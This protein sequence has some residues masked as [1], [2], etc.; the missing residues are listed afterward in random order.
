MAVYELK[1]NSIK[2]SAC[3]AVISK[4]AQKYNAKILEIDDVNGRVKISANSDYDFHILKRELENKLYAEISIRDFIINSFLKKDGF[5]D[6]Y[7]KLIEF[8]ITILLMSIISSLFMIFNLIPAT[9][10]NF[11]IFI[12]LIYS[13]SFSNTVSN[14]LDKFH[15]KIDCNKAMMCGMTLSM[16]IGM[17]FGGL[18]AISNGLF[19]GSIIGTTLGLIYGIKH[20]CRYAMAHIES[21]IG[22][23][24]GGTMGAML[25]IMLLYDNLFA[26][27]IFMAIIHFLALT[28]LSYLLKKDLFLSSENLN[29][30]SAKINFKY[31]L[32]SLIFFL[33]II[34]SILILP[35]GPQTFFM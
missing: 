8:L 31:I 19:Y 26:F 23:F 14:Y 20:S 4:L 16:T 13:V 21:V 10:Q 7:Y 27:L 22:A 32:H 3:S 12:L 1:L 30:D 2:C 24:M 18:I 15:Q 5:E 11:I 17:I 28:L 6:E 29:S 9:Q 25:T 35:K 33:I 34:L